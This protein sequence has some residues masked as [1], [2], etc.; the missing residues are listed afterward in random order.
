MLASHC[1]VCHVHVRSLHFTA[2]SSGL[3]FGSGAG[4]LSKLQMLGSRGPE[5]FRWGH[6]TDLH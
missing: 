3:Y 4:G 6:M 5:E 2:L 1:M